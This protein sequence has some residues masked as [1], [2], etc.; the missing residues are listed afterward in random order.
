MSEKFRFIHFADAHIG[1]AGNSSRYNEFSSLRISKE[2]DG[3]NVRTLD[4]NKA[5]TQIIDLAIEHQVDAVVDAGD[6]FDQWGYKANSVFNF[7]QNQI[8][9]LE[10]SNIPYIGIIGNHDLP[11]LKNKGTYLEGLSILDNT[12]L[13]YNGYYESFEL[14]FEEVVFHC[15]PSSFRQDILD[16]SLNEVS[17]VEGKINIGV[18]HFGVS[19]IKHYAENSINSLVIELDRLIAA[20]MDYFA[21]GDYH[22]PTTFTDTIR[23][24][25]SIERLGFGEINVKPQVLLVEIDK[26]TKK[27]KTTPIF[28]DVRPMVDL[29]PLD[30][31]GLKIDEINDE[32][33]RRLTEQDLTEKIVR[34]R[35]KN[36]PKDYKRLIDVEKIK[37]LTESTL[38]FK[39][40]F[41]DK[42]NKT[43]EAKTAGNQFEGVIQ[44]WSNFVDSI[45]GDGTFD[46]EQL[47][48]LGLT[49][50]LEVYED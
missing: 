11:K 3:V 36:L 48:E 13:A 10:K 43:K 14:P 9:R 47:K 15:V 49:K 45:E 35:V 26:K 6:L 29:F 25:G 23:Y 31:K 41:V 44:G 2:I 28:L 4:L 39:I 20:E 37:D 46:K 7:V 32:I 42:V 22:E 34:F 21:L 18:G 27:V 5:Y 50:L 12:Y 40:E 1:Y 30:A 16:D 19:T 17:P 38:Y 24:S 8:K 33:A